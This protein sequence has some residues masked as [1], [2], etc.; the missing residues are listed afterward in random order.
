MVT[1][2]K[3]EDL[4][5]WK[6]KGIFITLICGIQFIIVTLIAMF[7]YPRPYNFI[8]D[9]F[10]RLGMLDANA[11]FFGSGLPYLPNN[12]SIIMF[13]I[14]ILVTAV[15][16]IP[17][18]FVMPSVYDEKKSTK[19]LSW[20]GSLFG[21]ASAP[22]LMLVAVPADFNAILHTVGALGFF[23]LFA[24]AIIIYTV[25]L[26]LNEKYDN[27]L[28]AMGIIAM[29]IGFSYAIIGNFY[30]FLPPVFAYSN[31]FHQKL[32]V[33]SFITWALIQIFIIWKDIEE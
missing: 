19:I 7:F 27:K 8:M 13:I 1:M 24:I 31:A 3:L 14:T 18:W 25:G 28:I 9:H 5:G 4:Q 20:G 2:I 15:G 17:F 11:T 22:F 6:R 10:S 32:A 29:V 12:I 23:L 21:I 33:Y 16:I 26:L 30:D